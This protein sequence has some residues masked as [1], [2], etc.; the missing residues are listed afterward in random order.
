MGPEDNRHSIRLG[1]LLG[2]CFWSLFRS[3]FS[4]GSSICSNT[5]YC[6][7]RSQDH[8]RGKY[9]N[10]CVLRVIPNV[11]HSCCFFVCE[12]FISLFK[13]GVTNTTILVEK[14][15]TLDQFINQYRR[16]NIRS[17]S[18]IK[19]MNLNAVSA[20]SSL[21]IQKRSWRRKSK[22]VN[23]PDLDRK[24][25]SSNHSTE[26]HVRQ[27]HTAYT[28]KWSIRRGRKNINKRAFISE[29]T[30]GADQWFH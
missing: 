29:M 13:G 8:Y 17:K 12:V 11:L 20:M 10:M 28:R 14:Y 16:R 5:V 24:K 3:P 7:A 21:G 19:V 2:L 25:L 6:Y 9:L 22:K 26:C 23:W 1:Y 18:N 30:D 15:Q 27:Q 4:E